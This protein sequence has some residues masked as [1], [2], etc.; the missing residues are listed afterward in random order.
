MI[1]P[2]PITVVV[3]GT[4]TY[5]GSPTFTET[6]N[7]PPGVTLSGTLS[8]NTV[9]SSTAIGASLGAG[10]YTIL[11]TSCGGFTPSDSTDYS[12]TY[13]GAT[14]GFVVSQ[15]TTTTSL[16]T[17]PTATQSYLSQADTSFVVTVT[18]GNGESLSG[19]SVTVTVTGTVGVTS[20]LANL[21]ADPGVGGQGSCSVANGALPAGDYTASAQ[22]PGDTNLEES[23][24]PATTPFD[25]TM[26]LFHTSLSNATWETPYPPTT[27]STKGNN[28]SVTYSESGALPQGLGLSTGGVLS[29][30]PT[31]K[32]QIGTTFHFSVTATDS[33]SNTVT[34]SFAIELLSPCGAGLTPYFLSAT[35][36]TAS[37]TGL[38]CVNS[39]GDGT[40]TQG[41]VNGTGSVTMSGGVTKISAFGTDLALIGQQTSSS[42]I[43]SE[44]APLRSAG[45]FTLT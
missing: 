18:T 23:P 28:G 34:Q 41:S 13:V 2:V 14:N 1:V 12:V 45:T 9:G 38:F 30:T 37:F 25:V 21:S 33:H 32:S 16:S 43:F 27:F 29:G 19:E 24:G 26:N 35:S 11:G 22:Y 8:C 39:A 40:Y 17:T 7:S 5:G 42:T 10:S 36:R 31:N 3:S 20:C 15:D 4:Q 6:D 44:T